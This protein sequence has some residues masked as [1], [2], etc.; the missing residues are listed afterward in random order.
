MDNEVFEV[1]LTLSIETYYKN[2][3][4]IRLL[5]WERDIFLMTNAASAQGDLAGIKSNDVLKIRFLREGNAYGFVADVL[6]VQFYPFPLM[7]LSYPGSIEFVKLRIAPR[8]K[9][10]LP[11]TLRRSSDEVDLADSTMLDIS[12]GGC[13]LKVPF[14]TGLKLSPDISYTVTFKALDK[15]LS[16][17]C[18]IRKLKENSEVY[19]LGLE[20]QDVSEQ[21]KDSLKLF[22]EFIKKH[23]RA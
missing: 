7:F 8:F 18:V 22:L 14:K 5:G 13:G 9:V 4:A 1:G 15:E 23:I 6:H 19:T 11:A 10:D 3:T 17:T 20:F 21:D 16:I 2:Y 12:E